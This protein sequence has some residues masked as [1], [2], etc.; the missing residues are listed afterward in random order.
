MWE[1][2]KELRIAAGKYAK[3]ISFIGAFR[4]S[5]KK[6]TSSGQTMVDEAPVMKTMLMS[7]NNWPEI[8]R[9]S[10]ISPVL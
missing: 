8:G 4:V 6:I 5:C 1:G 7:A 3:A 9:L 2:R 10:L